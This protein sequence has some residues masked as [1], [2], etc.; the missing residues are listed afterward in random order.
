MENKTVKLTVGAMIAALYVVLTFISH[1]MGLASG[2]IQLRLSEMLTVLPVFSGAA[3][4]GLF[5]G[6]F[7][8]NL[9]T[10]SALWDVVFG[11]IATLLGAL[12][13]RRFRRY[14]WSAPLFPI[15]SNAVIVPFILQYVYKAEGIY[16]YF[17]ATVGAGEILSCGALGILFIKLLERTKVSE[18][19]ERLERTI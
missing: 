19:L 6:C 17:M 1:S 18:R 9:L 8:A 16:F 15:L 14:K 7:L 12:G 10:G 11:S 5:V 2:A 4:P 3:V 13:T